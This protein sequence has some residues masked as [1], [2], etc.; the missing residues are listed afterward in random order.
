VKFHKSSVLLKI[1]QTIFK[2]YLLCLIDANFISKALMQIKKYSDPA[3]R[4]QKCIISVQIFKTKIYHLLDR[5]RTQ[6]FVY[7]KFEHKTTTVYS[8]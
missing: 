8:S 5:K 4:T 6:C 1:I 3:K 2:N 7:K